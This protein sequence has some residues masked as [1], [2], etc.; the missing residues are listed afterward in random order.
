MFR[1]GKQ[2]LRLMFG[3][4]V[5]ILISMDRGLGMELC[6]ETHSETLR[7]F[8]ATGT[9]LQKKITGPHCKFQQHRNTTPASTWFSQRS[10]QGLQVYEWILSSPY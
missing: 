6:E 1:T 2:M 7:M 10:T 4:F 3:F 5:H 9:V 8:D